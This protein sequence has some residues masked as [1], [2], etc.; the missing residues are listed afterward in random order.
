MRVPRPVPRRYGF[1]LCGLGLFGRN[2]I[3]ECH[4][5]SQTLEFWLPRKLFPTQRQ[6]FV[7]VLND[8]GLLVSGFFFL[9]HEPVIAVKL[10]RIAHIEL[11]REPTMYSL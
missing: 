3:N 10:Y 11:E 8:L 6:H 7:V 9:Q 5:C 4:S 2:W 1:G